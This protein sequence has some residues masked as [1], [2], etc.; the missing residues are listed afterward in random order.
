MDGTEAF[1]HRALVMSG[2]IAAIKEQVPKKPKRPKRPN[3]TEGA[4]V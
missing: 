2:A 1:I 3:T 4:T